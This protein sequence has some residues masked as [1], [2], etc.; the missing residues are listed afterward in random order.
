[1]FCFVL[2]L[3]F[4]F[5]FGTLYRASGLE[6]ARP[7]GTRREEKRRRWTHY[8]RWCCATRFGGPTRDLERY[9]EEVMLFGG[10]TRNLEH[11]VDWVGFQFYYFFGAPRYNRDL[12]LKKLCGDWFADQVVYFSNFLVL[13]MYFQFVAMHFIS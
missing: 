10:S 1:M 4:A 2:V 6:E 3:G 12:L 8:L 11:W 9:S 5:G 13:A 7:A